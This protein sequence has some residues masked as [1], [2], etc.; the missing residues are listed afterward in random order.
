MVS[1]A[2]LS[3]KICF[4]D[5]IPRSPWVNPKVPFN[6]PAALESN[7]NYARDY[8]TVGFTTWGA[9]GY[10]PS[11]ESGLTIDH[12]YINTANNAFH[13]ETPVYISV[14]EYEILH[15]EDVELYEHLKKVDGNNVEMQ[16][17]EYAV[18]DIILTAP[19]N[20][21]AAEAQRAAKRAGVFLDK[22]IKA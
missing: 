7:A 5:G 11:V 19:M 20:G 6:D 3:S 2:R 16:V 9:R 17:E 12:P 10:A 21:F 8:L 22:H 18:H 4:T 14:G 1:L 15:D 13:T